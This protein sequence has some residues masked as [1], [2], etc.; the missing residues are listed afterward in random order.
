[1]KYG[2]YILIVLA[3]FLQALGNSMNA[4][5]K[6]SLQN[7]WL[8]SLVSFALITAFFLIAF[9]VMPRPLPSVEG[10]TAMPWWAPVGGLAGAV[11]V[12]LGLL[13]VAKIG[14]GAFNGLLITANILSSLL[15]DH[16][17]WANMPIHSLNFGRVV[18]GIFMVAG[19]LLISK[20]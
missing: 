17:G 6:S 20:Y 1:M 7:P 15:I 16:W 5:L 13:F 14:A 11:A 3:G 4:Q 12:F 18:G 10:V 19:I 9:A 8:A 2:L